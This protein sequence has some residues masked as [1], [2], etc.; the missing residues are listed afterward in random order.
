MQNFVSFWEAFFPIISD[1]LTTEP[2]IWFVGI[3]VLIMIAGFI[4]KIIRLK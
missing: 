2:V 3:I 4:M 1:F